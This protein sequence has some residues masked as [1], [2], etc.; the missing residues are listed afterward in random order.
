LAGTGA[1]DNAEDLKKIRRYLD[2]KAGKRKG[3]AWK[4]FF[5]ARHLLPGE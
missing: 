1:K 4:A 2:Q 3:E 5:A